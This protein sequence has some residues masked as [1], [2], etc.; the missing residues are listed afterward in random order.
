MI[1]RVLM[2][3]PEADTPLGCVGEKVQQRE[4]KSVYA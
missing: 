4:Y 3:V 1:Q 2:C